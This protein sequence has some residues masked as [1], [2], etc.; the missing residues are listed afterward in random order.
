MKKT[1]D[2]MYLEGMLELCERLSKEGSIVFPNSEFEKGMSAAYKV[3]AEGI[4]SHLAN[5]CKSNIE[6][7]YCIKAP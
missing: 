7:S 6:V 5:E 1:S 3:V 2:R 4:A